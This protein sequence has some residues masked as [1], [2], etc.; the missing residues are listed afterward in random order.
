MNLKRRSEC[1]ELDFGG[2]RF[3]GQSLPEAGISGILFEVY[4]WV[5]IFRTRI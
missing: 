5:L 2:D 4:R 1:G 3:R